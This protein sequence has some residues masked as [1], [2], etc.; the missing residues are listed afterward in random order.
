MVIYK[1]N[2]F[3]GHV[4]ASFSGKHR[5]SVYKP[6]P[7]EQWDVLSSREQMFSYVWI[8]V[9]EYRSDASTFNKC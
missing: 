9:L 3:G 1:S 5:S 6:E 4:I 7:L 8:L 2:S